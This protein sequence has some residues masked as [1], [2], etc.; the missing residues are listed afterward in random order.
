MLFLFVFCREGRLGGVLGLGW[1]GRG[2]G[3][4]GGGVGGGGGE[5]GEGGGGGGGGREGAL[6]C[7]VVCQAPPPCPPSPPS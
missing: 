3:G 1:V 5:G 7:P 4:G 2:V 6:Y